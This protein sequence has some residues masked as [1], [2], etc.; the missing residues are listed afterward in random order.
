MAHRFGVI[1]QDIPGKPQ[2]FKLQIPDDDVSE[3]KQLL[4]ASKIG[5]ATWWNERSDNQFGVS[6]EWLINAKDAWLATF[7]WRKHEERINRFPNFKISLD[8]PDAGQFDIHFAALFSTKKDAVP[9]IFMHGWPGSF[10]E[11]LPMMDLLV[12]KY[13]PETLPYH[14]IVPSIPDY[15]L[16][17]RT[18]HGTEVTPE[19]AA[20]IMNQLMIDLGF[21]RGYMAQGGDVGS[22]L[23]RFM[24]V[25]YEACKAIHRA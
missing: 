8:D 21:E 6:R 23:S 25:H 12:E 5:P 11:F 1:P 22:M 9:I 4:S 15:G 10:L 24:S 3:L 20:R 18:S 19:H 7:D 2:P 17:S 13:T 14:V 16:S